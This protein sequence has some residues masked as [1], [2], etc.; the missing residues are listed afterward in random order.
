VGGGLGRPTIDECLLRGGQVGKGYSMLM[1]FPPSPLHPLA[2]W[3]GSKYGLSMTAVGHVTPTRRK[4][5]NSAVLASTLCTALLSHRSTTIGAGHQSCLTRQGDIDHQRI[6]MTPTV[7][8]FLTLHHSPAP[9]QRDILLSRRS[10]SSQTLQGAG[11]LVPA[12][13][14]LTHLA[15]SILTPPPPQTNTHTTP[16]LPQFAC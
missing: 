16:R 11:P 8:P 12:P 15:S 14:S 1:T 3:P 4:K 5:R 2:A 6:C 7:C 9:F 10:S 13:D